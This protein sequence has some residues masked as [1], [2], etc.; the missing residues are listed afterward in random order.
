MEHQRA[1]VFFN[2]T[3]R[4]LHV[5]HPFPPNQ[6]DVRRAAFFSL[7]RFAPDIKP[8]IVFFPF[9][10]G[11]I[12]RIEALEDVSMQTDC[13][14]LGGGAGGLC[15]AALAAGAARHGGRAPA[16]RGQDC[17]PRERPLQ[18]VQS[19]Y[20]TVALRQGRA[21]RR[22]GLCRRAAGGGRRLLLARP[23]DRRGG[24]PRLSPTMAASA[25]LDV[26]RMA[27]ERY[28]VSMLTDTE[29][30][31]LSHPD[32]AAGRCSLQ[33]V[34][35]FCTARRRR[36]GRKRRAVDGHGRNGRV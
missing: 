6:A 23:D 10:Y 28:A 7:S 8:R 4:R 20:A 13:V 2:V 36:H 18:P 35:G 24:R 26:L 27:C 30:V 11:I 34:R 5:V 9:V 19:G 17:W 31:A 1:S 14:I 3:K 29:V 22:A 15:A 25:V 33:M 32:A 21:V 16:A 12:N